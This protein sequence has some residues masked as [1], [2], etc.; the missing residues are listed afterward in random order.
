MGLCCSLL[1]TAG[2]SDLAGL[3]GPQRLRG[4]A[5]ADGGCQCCHGVLA[6]VADEESKSGGA[7]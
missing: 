7:K 4:A 3:R 1:S 6:G 5:D 2:G